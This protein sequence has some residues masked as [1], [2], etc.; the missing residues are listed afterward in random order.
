MIP[1]RF[2]TS[3]I[4]TIQAS[5]AL[6]TSNK[7]IKLLAKVFKM[8]STKKRVKNAVS[9]TERMPSSIPKISAIVNQNKIKTV[10][11]EIKII[12]IISKVALSSVFK[13]NI[14]NLGMNISYLGVARISGVKYSFSLGAKK[15]NLLPITK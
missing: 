4:I 5:K 6:K 7:N 1:I 14:L 3:D 13:H 2:K 9:I 8:I 15:P 11:K 10:Y 12:D